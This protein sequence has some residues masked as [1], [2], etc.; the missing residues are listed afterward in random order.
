[1]LKNVLAAPNQVLKMMT[2][3]VLQIVARLSY[4]PP[5]LLPTTMNW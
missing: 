2:L 4:Q 3:R 1:M 5:Q